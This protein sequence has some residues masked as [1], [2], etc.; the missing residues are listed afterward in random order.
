MGWQWPKG[1]TL[2]G[3]ALEKGG[4]IAERKEVGDCFVNGMAH[5][6]SLKRG[7]LKK[8]SVRDGQGRFSQV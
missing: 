1:H 4:R 8:I 6:A 2:G 7:H 3:T 5:T